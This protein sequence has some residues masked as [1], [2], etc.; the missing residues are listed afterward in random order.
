MYC[1]IKLIHKNIKKK[2]E[3]SYL[4][5]NKFLVERLGLAESLRLIV[6]P[7]TDMIFLDTKLFIIT[8]LKKTFVY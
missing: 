1:K 7:L 4:S 2:N 8:L 5:E 6:K 3:I